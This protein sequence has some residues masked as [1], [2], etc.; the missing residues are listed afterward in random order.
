M[1]SVITDNFRIKNASDFLEN[2]SEKNIYLFVGKSTPWSSPNSDSNPPNPGDT[3]SE[4]R[5]SHWND[6]L[7]AKKITNNESR[8]AVR[9]YDWNSGE[10]YVQ[11]DPND[12]DLFR[13]K[14]YVLT[15]TGGV[16]NV[17]KCLVSP[18]SASTT[19][20]SGTTPGVVINTGDGY[21]WLYLYT[22]SSVDAVKFL[23]PQHMPVPQTKNLANILPQISL[24]AGA[25]PIVP[26]SDD[27]VI[28]HGYDIIRE[29]GAY[30]VNINQ[31]LSGNESLTLTTSNDYRKIG[32]VEK[33]FSQTIRL[34]TNYIG[35]G[36]TTVT[37]TVLSTVN[38][39]INVGDRILISG[40]AGTEQTKLNGE[41]IVSAKPSS[42]SFQFQINST[43]ASNTYTSTIGTLIHYKP[44]T[45]TNVRQTTK[46]VLTNG[47]SA[48]VLD[49]TISSSSGGQ[50]IV[51]EQNP[52][53]EIQ[54][55]ITSGTFNQG[56]TIT[57]NRGTGNVSSVIATGGVSLPGFRKN[58]GDIIYVE[59]RKPIFRSDDQTESI[60]VILEFWYK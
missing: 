59:Y 36:T 5:Y 41:W 6:M 24:P 46:L 4:T 40:A 44:A 51:V 42:T 37:A 58:S 48:Y 35:N 10:T 23:T 14:F 45:L 49:E 21:R 15:S 30:F 55:I 28:G 27:G 16:Y 39:E 8:Q 22:I 1:A 12:I 17:Y 26:V 3:I 54:I 11:Y 2:M 19:S 52:S 32:L 29:L 13:K 34:V 57:T 43:L 18:G 31:T 25:S 9:R 33:P 56:D 7:G 60:S 53:T 47:T 20:P 38:S 50:A